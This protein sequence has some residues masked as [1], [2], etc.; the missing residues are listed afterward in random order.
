MQLRQTGGSKVSGALNG[1]VSGT[2]DCTVRGST[3][4]GV[5]CS[6]NCAV[7]VPERK[8]NLGV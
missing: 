2:V 8:V 7:I 6:A 3:D 4:S 1:A 5:V